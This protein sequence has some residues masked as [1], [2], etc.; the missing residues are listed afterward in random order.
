MHTTCPMLTFKKKCRIPK[1]FSVCAW[2]VNGTDVCVDAVGHE[3]R[4][5]VWRDEGDG[6]VALEA[7]Q[8]DTLVELDILH[9][10]RL[11]LVT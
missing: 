6:A 9:G 4:L 5:P 3:L 7:G 10:H 8:T 2:G 11:A 1:D